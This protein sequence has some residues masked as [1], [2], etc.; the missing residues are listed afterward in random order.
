[1]LIKNYNYDQH[2][3]SHLSLYIKIEPSAIQNGKELNKILIS[4]LIYYI[5][6]I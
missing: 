3:A 1:M 6:K 2:K 4:H 5:S